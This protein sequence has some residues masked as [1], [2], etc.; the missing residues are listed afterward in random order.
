MKERMKIDGGLAF[1]MVVSGLL[2]IP[3][4]GLLPLLAVGAAIATAI[5]ILDRIRIK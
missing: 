3:T 5:Y 1:A 4:F 2:M